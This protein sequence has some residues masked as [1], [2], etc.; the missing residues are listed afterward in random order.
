MLFVGYQAPGTLGA[1]IRDG[2]SRVRIRGEEINVKAG[3][4]AIDAYSGHAD[5]DA[6]VDWAMP[7]TLPDLGSALLVHGEPDVVEGLTDSLSMAGLERMRI[8]APELDQAFEIEFRD[9]RSAG[10]SLEGCRHAPPRR[11]PGH[12]AARLAQ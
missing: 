1:L 2:A 8:L 10:D 11:R 3:I 9:G 4:R 12:G 5:R 6:L 7:S